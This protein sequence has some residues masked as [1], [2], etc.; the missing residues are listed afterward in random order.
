MAATTKVYAFDGSGPTGHDVTAG[1]GTVSFSRA[2][3][4][5][6]TASQITI[7]SPSNRRFS[8]LRYLALYVT[9][10]GGSTT[11][12]NLRMKFA[13]S[14][15][16]GL[17]VHALTGGQSTYTQNNGSTGTSAG[18]YPA[19][20]TVVIGTA[21]TGY[22]ALST[23]DYTYD[24]T[25]GAATNSAKS[26]KYAQCVAAVTSSYAGGGGASTAL[27]NLTITYDES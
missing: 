25:G 18:N 8:Y 15:T 22:T 11:L 21:P 2:D 4:Y 6:D 14:I 13:T 19:D 17:E 24:A 9:A 5:N 23:S 7:P 12:S 10:G 3:A 1:T 20:D 27:P 26:G 16:S